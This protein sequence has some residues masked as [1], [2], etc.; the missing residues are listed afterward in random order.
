MRLRMP[1]FFL[2]P[3]MAVSIYAV[4]QKDARTTPPSPR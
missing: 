1:L 2:S 4:P 3:L